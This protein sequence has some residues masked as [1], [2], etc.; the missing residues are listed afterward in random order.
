[1]L[2]A[3]VYNL[4]IPATLKT[5][6]DQVVRAGI[7]FRFTAEGPEGLLGVERA[8]IVTN[9]GGTPIG[10]PFD[11]NTPYLRT[12][13]AFVGIADVRVIAPTARLDPSLEP[14]EWLLEPTG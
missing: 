6:I 12:I 3:P 9:S 14:A 10:S 11:F 2:V 13:L 8:W 7:T 4:G 5:W 1:V